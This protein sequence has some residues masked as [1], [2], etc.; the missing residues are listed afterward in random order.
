MVLVA[1]VLTAGTYLSI[2]RLPHLRDLWT[3]GYGQVL[4]VKIALVGVALAWGGFHHFFV[5][6]RLASGGR[7]VR[8][9]AV[10]R[11]LLG[12]SL[13][14]MAVLLAAAVL[15]DSKPPPQP[16]KQPPAQAVQPLRSSSSRSRAA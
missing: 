6:P 5:R 11:S 16:L 9:T 13:V 4:L 7:R 12:E 1:V 3:Q 15:V 14:G 2:V 8:R 10:G